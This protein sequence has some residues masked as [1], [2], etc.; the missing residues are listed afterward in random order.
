MITDHL[1]RGTVLK[2]CSYHIYPLD[3]SPHGGVPALRTLEAPS[4][5]RV[6]VAEDCGSHVH[7]IPI[8]F[9]DEPLKTRAN[10][11]PFFVHR[12]FLEEETVDQR[13]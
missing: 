11:Y 13:R 3:G 7:D 6:I 1:S 8:H 5:T 12:I 2:L 9:A 10:G 4:G